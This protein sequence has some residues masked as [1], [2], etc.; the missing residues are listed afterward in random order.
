MREKCFAVV[1]LIEGG[2]SLKVACETL[3]IAMQRFNEHKRSDKDLSAAYGRAM[4]TRA[5]YLAEQIIEIADT[6]SDSSKARNQIDARKWFAAKVHPKQYGERVD[7]NVTQSIDISA[8]LE[9]A[10]ARLL[11]MRDQSN[12]IDA[13]AIDITN[14]KAV[15]SSDCKSEGPKE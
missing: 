11:S 15:A 3:G 6:E 2:Q 4:E 9:E 14:Q 8:A 1:D 10:R 7:L 12:I 5:D 13:Q